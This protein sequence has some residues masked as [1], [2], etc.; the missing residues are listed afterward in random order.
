V[1]V[2]LYPLTLETCL[3]AAVLLN[4][5]MFEFLKRR[6]KVSLSHSIIREARKHPHPLAVAGRMRDD[7]RSGVI[8]EEELVTALDAIE[9]NGQT[10]N[11]E[12]QSNER[13]TGIPA[14]SRLVEV[15]RNNNVQIWKSQ[16]SLLKDIRMGGYIVEVDNAQI[17]LRLG[18]IEIPDIERWL[19]HKD[20][21][22]VGSCGYNEF[23]NKYILGDYDKDYTRRGIMLFCDNRPVGYIKL[24]GER[25]FLALRTV[26]NEKGIPVLIKG[27][28]YALDDLG[29]LSLRAQ[30]AYES[31]SYEKGVWFSANIED[32][33]GRDLIVGDV[34]EAGNKREPVKYNEMRF[35]NDPGI[36]N[37]L[38][39]VVQ[40]IESGTIK[41]MPI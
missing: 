38:T 11:L 36:F 31:N 13:Y 2:N 24:I 16:N 28:I 12:G 21:A 32:I 14:R 40:E 29:D 5:V 22:F 9:R 41:T 1:R 35:V 18:Q 25:S 10:I 34:K 17:D 6:R 27:V 15:N 33:V 8:T 30:K 7:V 4:V 39:H 37:A 20:R 23:Y 19:Q 3:F 26:R